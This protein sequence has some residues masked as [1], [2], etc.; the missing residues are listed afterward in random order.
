M[1]DMAKKYTAEQM[2]EMAPML[3][4][5]PLEEE[6]FTSLIANKEVEQKWAARR[7]HLLSEYRDKFTGEALEDMFS[8]LKP[9]DTL[10][11]E[12]MTEVIKEKRKEQ[13]EKKMEATKREEEQRKREKE[14][15]RLASRLQSGRRTRSTTD[16]MGD[17]DVTQ[18]A[19]TS[20]ERSRS[21]KAKRVGD[22]AKATAST[23]ETAAKGGGVATTTAAPTTM[24][25][26]G[27]SG[28]ITSAPENM[29]LSPDAMRAAVRSSLVT[30]ARIIAEWETAAMTWSV[31]ELELA[32][33][34][35]DPVHD[36]DKVCWAH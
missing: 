20:D 13:K 3:R 1:D 16:I 12:V 11:K 18:Q 4:L 17:A 7:E 22:G 9:E 31:A 26:A 32:L 23:E 36:A 21:K 15:F 19:E 25:A 30:R 28:T 33:Q 14:S 27:A 35:L 29:F 5:S 34:R 8:L 6:Y 10:E 24:Q 2:T